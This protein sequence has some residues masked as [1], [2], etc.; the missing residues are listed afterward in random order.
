LV[1]GGVAGAVPVAVGEVGAVG[2][3]VDVGG[4]VPVAVGVAVGT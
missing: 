4:V 3:V 2:A 1:V